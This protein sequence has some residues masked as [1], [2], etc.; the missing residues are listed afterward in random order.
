[1]PV[2]VWPSYPDAPITSEYGWRMHPIYG[3]PKWHNGVDLGIPEGSPIFASSSGRIKTVN[4]DPTVP[5]GIFIVLDH[6]NG[7]S[8]SYSHL[9]EVVVNKGEF[10]PQGALIGL[11]GNTGSS[12]G[13][14]LHWVVRDPPKSE[15]PK[16]DVNPL[17]YLRGNYR[18]KKGGYIKGGAPPALLGILVAAGAGY[19]IY[20]KARKKKWI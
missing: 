16:G 13:A 15:R 19:W 17:N 20:K 3:Y 7:M 2:L 12:T 1:M 11:S 4:P 9:S 6:Q 10:V 5:S 18:L 14:H 8:S